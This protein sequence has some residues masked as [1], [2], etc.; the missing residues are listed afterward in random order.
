MTNPSTTR[1]TQIANAAE[2]ELDL[3]G[4]KILLVDDNQQN[5]S[6]SWAIL[7]PASIALLQV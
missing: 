1:Q 2:E 7:R 3:V 4:A 6:F 5:H